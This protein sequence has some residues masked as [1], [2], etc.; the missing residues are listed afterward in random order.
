M[1]RCF[2]PHSGGR[3]GF[4][5]KISVHLRNSPHVQK[6]GK[7]PQLVLLCCYNSDRRCQLPSSYSETQ[8]T[9][10][11]IFPPHRR[12]ACLSYILSVNSCFSSTGRRL[13]LR[14]PRL[15]FCGR[16]VQLK[17]FFMKTFIFLSQAK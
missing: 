1:C 12:P 6:P 7:E 3:A 10:S 11:S 2:P 5:P 4:V 9:K 14:T 15:P 8:P 16:K 13:V 17:R